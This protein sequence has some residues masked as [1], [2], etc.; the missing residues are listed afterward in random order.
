MNKIDNLIGMPCITIRQPWAWLI[1]QG[2]KDIENRNWKTSFRGEILI[3]AAKGMTISEYE[4][5]IGLC[6]VVSKVNPFPHNTR[7]PPYSEMKRGGIIGSTTITDCVKESL[8]PWFFGQYGFTLE[9]S[10]PLP[11]VPCKGQL[12]IFKV[13]EE[14]IL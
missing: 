5:C 12:G 8:S 2:F 7:M 6:K 1:V 10:K 13:K 4:D 9:N 3:H 11:F 14:N